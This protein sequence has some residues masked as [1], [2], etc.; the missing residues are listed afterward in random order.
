MERDQSDAPP[1]LTDSQQSEVTEA[2]KRILG[3]RAPI[4]QVKGVLVVIYGIT[5]DQAFD[6][7][8]ECS[9][10]ANIKL[11][12]I[13]RQLL[14]DIRKLDRLP[15]PSHAAVDELLRTVHER[16]RH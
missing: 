4:E 2:L 9:Q 12:D 1:E 11:H 10:H 7:L 3:D 14:D 8:C 13:A 16:I 15:M 6:K 5:A